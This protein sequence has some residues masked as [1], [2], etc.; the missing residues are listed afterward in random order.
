MIMEL[1]EPATPDYSALTDCVLGVVRQT[2]ERKEKE[3]RLPAEALYEEILNEV[4][5]QVKA[6]L[7][8]LVTDGILA[9]HRT[10]NSV[11]FAFRKLEEK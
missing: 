4:T 2:I 8:S 3:K 9:F 11:C 6:S 10:L 5:E 7:N 1:N